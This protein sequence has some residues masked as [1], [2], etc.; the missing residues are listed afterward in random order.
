MGVGR[1]GETLGPGVG[2][3]VPAPDRGSDA[4]RDPGRVRPAPRPARL[5][6]RPGDVPVRGVPQLSLRGSGRRVPRGHGGGHRARRR[7]VRELAPQGVR[8]RRGPNR[9]GRGGRPARRGRRQTR[10]RG[11]PRPVRVPHRDPGGRGVGGPR[12]G[13]PGDRGGGRTRDGVRLARRAAPGDDRRSGGT[14]RRGRLRRPGVP[15]RH[16]VRRRGAS[17]SPPGPSS[18]VRACNR[19]PRRPWCRCAPAT[20]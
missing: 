6:D 4:L 14:G 13:D 10:G 3:G 8:A 17:R 16:P 12:A 20:P 7:R 18:R 5:G 15:P 2:D 19:I 11:S 1:G 9:G